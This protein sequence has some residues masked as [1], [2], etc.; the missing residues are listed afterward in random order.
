VVTVFES[1]F[2]TL[3]AAGK[4]PWPSKPCP[5]F[6][7]LPHATGPG[8][9][10]APAANPPWQETVRGELWRPPYDIV[11]VNQ[12]IAPLRRTD[13]RPARDLFQPLPTA[14]V[15]GPA[16]ATLARHW[17]WFGKL[18]RLPGAWPIALVL[19]DDTPDPDRPDRLLRTVVGNRRDLDYL[20]REFGV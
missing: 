12:E 6:R 2:T 4:P 7:L 5:D 3:A 16:T 14:L 17:T 8:A 10:A 20:N 19:P 18:D 13:I 9:A 1:D 11:F 15:F